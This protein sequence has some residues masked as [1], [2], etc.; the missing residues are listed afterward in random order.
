MPEEN[1][2]SAPTVFETRVYEALCKVPSG[3][4]VTYK[5]LGAAV[6]CN[7]GQAIGNAMRRNPYAPQVPC[8]RVIPA[9]LKIGGYSGKTEGE[10]V[11]R[12]LELLA[13]EGVHFSEDGRLLDSDCLLDE[14]A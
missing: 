2:R 10:K 8:H 12:K 9:T 7:S 13:K 14:I 6:G 3:R 11:D 1:S 5:T 4:V